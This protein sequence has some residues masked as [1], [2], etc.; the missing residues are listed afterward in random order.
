MILPQTIGELLA[1]YWQLLTHRPKPDRCPMCG[2]RFDHR[3][4]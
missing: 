1:L 4:I 2:A 3:N